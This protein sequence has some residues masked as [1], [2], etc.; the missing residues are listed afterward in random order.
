M[1]RKLLSGLLDGGKADRLNRKTYMT[2]AAT[3]FLIVAIMHLLRI[4]FGW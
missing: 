3:L 2:V 1:S 4:I